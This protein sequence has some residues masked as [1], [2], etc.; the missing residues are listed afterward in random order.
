MPIWL[1]SWAVSTYCSEHRLAVTEDFCAQVLHP[2]LQD[3]AADGPDAGAVV[4][5]CHPGAHGPG[6]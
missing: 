4:L 2:G 6:R 5:H 3:A 1:A